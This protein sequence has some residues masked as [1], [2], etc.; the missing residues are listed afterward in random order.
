MHRPESPGE[1]CVSLTTRA[2]LLD[3][4][5]VSGVLQTG[6]IDAFEIQ[7]RGIDRSLTRAARIAHAIIPIRAARVSKRSMCAIRLRRQK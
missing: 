3:L 4:Q 2:A 5:A 7:W 1:R 6:F